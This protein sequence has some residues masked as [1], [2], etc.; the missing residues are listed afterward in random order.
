M[1]VIR[2]WKI[3]A[4]KLYPDAG[5]YRGESVLYSVEFNTV[6]PINTND[7][8]NGIDIVMGRTEAS[9]L[10]VLFEE[11]TEEGVH[12]RS[13]VFVY[14]FTIHYRNMLGRY[15]L[16]DVPGHID[17]YIRRNVKSPTILSRETLKEEWVPLKR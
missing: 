11:R 2:D 13:I 1:R 14:R 17:E 8:I 10:K 9:P 6:F 4:Q 15:S 7:F 12:V 5:T 16:I 3:S